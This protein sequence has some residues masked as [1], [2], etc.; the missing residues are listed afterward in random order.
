METGAFLRTFLRYIR[1]YRLQAFLLLVLLGID[2]AFKTAWPL[3]FKFLIDHALADRNQQL[4]FLT[5]GALLGGVLL[6]TLC[7]IIRDYFYAFLSARVVH[8]LRTRTFAHLQQLS[9]EFY[10]RTRP[11]DIMG[12]FSTDLVTVENSLSWVVASMILNG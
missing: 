2:V 1:P 12:R 9:L 5:L 3:S 4:L 7:S 8:D 10:N 11:G 6:A